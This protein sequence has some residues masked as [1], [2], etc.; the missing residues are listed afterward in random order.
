M[1]QASFI[2]ILIGLATVL[3]LGN[4][5][6]RFLT[7]LLAVRASGFPYVII[8]FVWF[9]TWPRIT[10]PIWRP[11]FN[12]LG[13]GLRGNWGKFLEEN[14]DWHWLHNVYKPF[15]SDTVLTLSLSG[16]ISMHTADPH[17]ISQI[18][19]RKN[20]FWKPIRLYRIL[21]I[22]GKNVLSV[23]GQVWRRHRKV[24]GP[25]FTERNNHL[26]WSESLYSAQKM[27]ESLLRSDRQTTDTVQDLEPLFGRLA[28]SVISKAG[29]GVRLAWPGREGEVAP[30]DEDP[31][32]DPALS[33]AWVDGKTHGHTMSFGDAIMQVSHSIIL[34]MLVPQWLLR[35]LPI[36]ACKKAYEAYWNWGN[37]MR[38]M[39]VAK[40]KHVGDLEPG[41]Q[42]YDLLANLVKSAA[43][44]STLLD[45]K[46]HIE[47]AANGNT[48]VKPQDKFTDDE[49][50]GNAFL[51]IIAGHETS[52]GAI[53]HSTLMLAMC[54]SH[55]RT[56][57][58][59]LDTLFPNPDPA[60]WD[61]E[62]DFAAVFAGRPGAILA[63]TLRLIPPVATPPKLV[64]HDTDITVDSVAHRLPADADI[65]VDIAAV[66]RNPKFW[67]HGARDP[68]APV[69]AG[70]GGVNP[71][72][73]LAEFKPQRWLV[74][75]E[76]AAAA[77]GST[78]RKT[79]ASDA[80]APDNASALFRPPKGAYLPFHEGPR[81]CMG[82]RFA[83]VEVLAI[84]ATLFRG[85]T[86]ELAVD[87]WASDEE[88]ARMDAGERRE[89][90]MKARDRAEGL[91]REGMVMVVTQKMLK[92][93]VPVR[94]V[95]RGE[96]RFKGVV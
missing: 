56:L 90:W 84:M 51:L 53:Q 12:S 41:K 4:N 39:I 6:F 15:G 78:E 63:E 86:V 62:R 40:R 36:I 34:I 8:P 33:K 19:Q 27:L 18:T 11:V 77:P 22:F 49:I 17:V 47:K 82:R 38:E 72:N 7:K 74:P 3:Y 25:P 91:F 96:E 61:Y 66:Q 35:N 94:F 5:L 29:Y 75:S 42:S 83:Q 52:A 20:D 44:S 10:A 87:E 92:G 50:L 60:T 58:A 80:D 93:S 81:A 73:D 37:Y 79:P 88:V 85:W 32:S 24:V 76:N 68:A 59:E 55:Q 64:K 14:S 26:V 43:D 67:P 89:V 30:A 46:E 21:D 28:L 70:A 9:D 54:P 45:D 48:P 16:Q 57:Q 71:G 13:P 2:S 23:E 95:R 69:F 1:A 65:A 31:S